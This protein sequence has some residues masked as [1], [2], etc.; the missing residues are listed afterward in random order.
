[1]LLQNDKQT[2]T[3]DR[4]RA[5]RILYDTQ[6]AIPTTFPI[7]E[8]NPLFNN[9]H[10]FEEYNKLVKTEYINKTVEVESQP[11]NFEKYFNDSNPVPQAHQSYRTKVLT[12]FPDFKVESKTNDT[13]TN[14]ANETQLEKIAETDILEIKSPNSMQT[15]KDLELHEP[16]LRLNA[17]GL[18]ACVAFV[19]ITA[20][21]AILVVMNI[22]AIGNNG[23]RINNLK[24]ENATLTQEYN[25]VMLEREAAFITGKEGAQTGSNSSQKVTLPPISEYELTPASSD[26]STN[27]FDQ[28]CKFLSS[29]FG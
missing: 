24:H 15:E 4:D 8:T 20:L 21:I 19:T 16:Y 22:V 3:L 29:I 9:N 14:I 1:M 13:I 10:N 26:Y 12:D 11:T 27:L 6:P 18:I 25:N 7:P 2:L 28:I 5:S 17:K 23:A